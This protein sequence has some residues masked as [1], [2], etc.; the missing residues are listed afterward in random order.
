MELGEEKYWRVAERNLNFV[1]ENQESDGSWKYAIA[2]DKNFID[3]FHTCFV[4]KALAKIE[5]L[6]ERN[7]SVPAIDRGVK[8]YVENLF[9]DNGLP[10]PFSIAPRLTVYRQELYDYAEC[11]NLGIL[12]QGR[13]DR[14]DLMTSLAA[15]DLLS[16]WQKHDGSFRSRRLVLGWDS[17]PMH[18]WAQSQIFRSLSLLLLTNLAKGN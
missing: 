16:R 10:K 14:L 3:H 2:G 11:I 8:Y 6:T 4:L 17:V 5:L 13:Y 1:L 7:L 9:Y 18:R 15:E 12:L